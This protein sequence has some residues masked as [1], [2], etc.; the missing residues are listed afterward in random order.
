M[1]A[2]VPFHPVMPVRVLRKVSRVTGRPGFGS[3]GAAGTGIAS[4]PPVGAGS[5]A[6]AEI[7]ASQGASI[8]SAI[9]PGIGTAIGAVI[10]AIGGAIAGAINKADP[11]N[12][13]F[14]QAVAVWQQNPDAVYSIRN[15]YL[16]LAGL[17]DL[18]ITT[19]IPIYRKFGHMGE[20]AFVVWLCNLVY[21]AAQNGTITPNDTALTVM[22]K[23]VQPAINAWGYGAMSDPH[24]D[25]INRLIVAMILQYTEGLETN[26]DAIGGCYPTQFNSIPPFGFPAAPAKTNPTVAAPMPNTPGG[27]GDAQANMPQRPATG[28][29]T[30]GA[31]ITPGS[32]TYIGDGAGEWFFG[33]DVVDESNGHGNAFYLATNQ[34]ATPTTNW[35]DGAGIQATVVGGQVYLQNAAGQW[36]TYNGVTWSQVSAPPATKATASNAA[37]AATGTPQ[38]P[39][40]PT[41]Q[42]SA[43][44]SQVTA[45]GTAL[46]TAAGT[47]IYLGPQAAGDPNNSLGY[48]VWENGTHS[49][50]AVGLLVLNGGQIYGVNA[51][52]AWFQWTDGGQWVAISGAPT[53]TTPATTSQV[54]S[55]QATQ[56]CTPK[57]TAGG[58]CVA[59][60]PVTNQTTGATVGTTTS[61]TPITDSDIQSLIDQMTS[62][63]ATAQQTYA[64]VMQALETSGASVTTGLQNQVAAQVEASTPA[65]TASSGSD[66]GLYIVGGG[67]ALVGLMFFLNRRKA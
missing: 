39:A 25:L 13:N 66:M 58:T 17:F 20:A 3:L 42:L 31:T 62:Q 36:W 10:G 37:A 2:L 55:Q 50:Y 32:G 51:Q 56:A 33:P 11:E 43:D 14:D 52:S 59:T 24:A 15:P 53:V 29:F 16:A 41:K 5:G 49:G 1:R 28:S 63:N 23:V 4:G 38:Q 40:L 60:P 64:A 65:S 22:S 47:L 19:N 18:N 45:P 21:Q 12:V 35:V 67:L 9:V 26:W 27:E 48:P 7:G 54:A 61:G 57:T 34:V 6:G 30:D 46:E 8:G 44:G